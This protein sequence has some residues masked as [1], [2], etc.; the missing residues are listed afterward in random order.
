MKGRVKK[1]YVWFVV[2]KLHLEVVWIN[3]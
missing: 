1:M 3:N 2:G